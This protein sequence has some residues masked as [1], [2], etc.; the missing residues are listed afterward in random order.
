MKANYF[1]LGLGLTPL[2][3]GQLGSYSCIADGFSHFRI[4][5]LLYFFLLF[6]IALFRKNRFLAV[7]SFVLTVILL[8]SISS[9]YLPTDQPKHSGETLRIGAINL[10]SSNRDFRTVKDYIKQS[11]FDV[12]IFQEYTP[13]WDEQLQVL[14]HKYPQIK[15]VPRLGN[16]GI[17]IYSRVPTKSIEVQNFSYFKIPTVFAKLDWEGKPIT[18]IGTHP[19]PP[20]N[21]LHFKARN[22]Q[23]KSLNQVVKK[24]AKKAEV[25]L[26]GDLNC[27]SFS[28]NFDLLTDGTMLIDTRKGR[29][30]QDSWNADISLIK[31]AI[32]HALVTDNLVVVDRKL[33]RN[34]GSDHFPLELEISFK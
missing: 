26:I 24:A 33:G 29:G 21:N 17:A 10:W 4:Y 7:S 14:R 12:I 3:L 8:I 31:V 2:L 1:W 6:L 15:R 23:F 16:F 9:F 27:T 19:V 13:R 28:P 20:I 32:D 22:N 11:D 18:I 34:I 30:L 5:Y 25:V